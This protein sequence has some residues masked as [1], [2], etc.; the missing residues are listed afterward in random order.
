MDLK[1]LKFDY[2]IANPPYGKQG[3]ACIPIIKK[4]QKVSKKS[5]ILAPQNIFF[6]GGIAKY[7]KDFKVLKEEKLF[8]GVV[9]TDLSIVT[10]SSEIQNKYTKEEVSLNS[11]ELE[12][13]SAI[14]NYKIDDTFSFH[15]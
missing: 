15:F 12:L 5:I 14:K 9:T 2:I 11:K 8:Q 3:T 13:A 10:L 6:K 1:N 7:A 4:I